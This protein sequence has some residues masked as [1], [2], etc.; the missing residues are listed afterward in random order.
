MS[1]HRTICADDIRCEIDAAHAVMPAMFEACTPAVPPANMY[2]AG[3]GFSVKVAYI[4]A[5]QALLA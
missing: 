3:N 5:S 1:L 4:A 2:I